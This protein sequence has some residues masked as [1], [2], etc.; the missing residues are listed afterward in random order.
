MVHNSNKI[1]LE[2]TSTGIQGLDEITNGGLPKGRPTLICGAAGCG[3]TMF[4][5]QF[6]VNGVKDNE[7]GLFVSFEETQEE[8][9]KNFASLGL[10]L[11]TLEEEKKFA[12][13]HIQMELSKIEETGEFNLEGLF[14]R[15]AYA[16]EQIGAKR[17]V[18]DTIEAIF[19]GLPNEFILR[20]ELQRLFHWLKSKG[21][22]AIITGERGENTLTR[23]GLE[24]Y[25]ADCVILL[26][27]SV[28]NRISTRNLR[29]IKYRGSSHGSNLYPFLIDDD[30]ISVLPVTSL[31][32]EHEVSTQR[33][34]TGIERL[35]TM[36][37]GKGFY[38][39][40]SILV[41][42]A[43]GTGKSSIAANIAANVCKNGDK[44][45]YFAFEESP[46]QI[47]RNMK[48]ISI[49]LQP[50][51][52]KGLLK[53]HATRPTLYG[54]ETH[55]V[56]INKI[57]KEFQPDV[58]I[59]DP[60]SNLITVGTGE[61]VKSMLT[62]VLDY[63]K[64]RLITTISTSL[65]MG[66]IETDI[67]VSS[68]MDTWINLKSIE[69][70]GERNR[71]IEIIKAR[72]MYHS[73]QVREFKL[74]NSGIKLIDVYIGPSGM[75]TGEDRLSQISKEKAEKLA[76]K[77]KLKENKENSNKNVCP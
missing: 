44:C 37:G 35:D 3:K 66:H 70:N 40:S 77:K 12:V 28:L 45:L 10:D 8:L 5:M 31:Q 33:I 50:W 68:L 24:E 76:P 42:G 74:T 9:E 22:T 23:Y 52:E 30:G 29:I 13:E 20:A 4:A 49:D 48:S 17:I 21:L 32:L 46:Q 54:L 73:N 60:V 36:F 65:T 53:F 34:Y 47:I 27:N 58:V 75:L 14:I 59:F 56:N 64:S 51:V 62:R 11:K 26:D 41:S 2:K 55:L 6:L 1:A 61:E 38:K 7:P 16:I 72:G 71:T 67:G 69:T 43:A 15:L 63:L 25:V 18:L 39:G 57:V 19:S